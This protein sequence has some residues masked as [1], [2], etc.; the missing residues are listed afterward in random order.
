MAGSRSPVR[1]ERLMNELER[2]RRELS[3]VRWRSSDATASGTL[4]ALRAGD[5][6]SVLEA[7]TALSPLDTEQVALQLGLLADL[8]HEL[9]ARGAI[10]NPQW[11]WY[12]D[13]DTLKPGTGGKTSGRV[14]RARMEQIVYRLVS[15]TGMH[16]AGN[17]AA[18]GWGAGSLEMIRTERDAHSVLPRAVVASVYPLTNLAPLLWN[19]A[20]LI[21]IGGN[22]GAHLFEVASWLGVPAVCGVELELAAGPAYA[23]NPQRD[24][25]AAV[26]GTR[27]T[28]ALTIP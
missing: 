7:L 16:L 3:A 17:P 20:G 25:V 8:G 5:D 18:A 2:G 24:I 9:S 22:P 10:S 11:M 12:V 14:G 27:G 6:R 26:D 23:G 4:D 19:A 28:V 1:I 21:T 15:G 13:A